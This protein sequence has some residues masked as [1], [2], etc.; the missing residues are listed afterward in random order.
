VVWSSWGGRRLLHEKASV[1]GQRGTP[2]S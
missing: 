2:W 1:Y